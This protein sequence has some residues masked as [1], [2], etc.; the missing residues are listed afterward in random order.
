MTTSRTIGTAAGSGTPVARVGVCYHPSLAGA[1]ELAAR[2]A[3]ASRNAGASAWL[4]P[5]DWNRVDVELGE[6]LQSTD[7]LVCVGGDGTVLHAAGH[8]AG[9][10]AA[11]LGVR[12]GRL[13]FLTETTEAEAEAVLTHALAGEGH[14]EARALVQARVNGGAP[15][16]ALN[17]LVIGR[18]TLGRTISIGAIVN[19]VVLAEYRADA[20]IVATAT[21]STGYALSVGGPILHPSSDDLVLAPVAPHLTKANPLVLPGRDTQLTLMVERGFDAVL[22]IDGGP[23]LVV[24]SGSEVRVEL[25]PLRARFLRLGSQDQFYANLARR[26]GWLRADHALGLTVEEEASGEGDGGRA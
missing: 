18:K 23:E 15:R 22:T 9:T 14:V 5:L 12:M 26:L 16:H 24:E 21:G 1:A 25:S 11:L 19:G 4:S 10:P 7:L 20:I 8:A 6:H 13:G 2:L 3:E 17:D